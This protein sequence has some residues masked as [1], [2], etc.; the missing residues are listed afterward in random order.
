MFTKHSRS[1]SILLIQAPIQSQREN[2]QL[3][4]CGEWF[5]NN[6]KD[7]PSAVF[8]KKKALFAVDANRTVLE[9]VKV[10]GK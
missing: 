6:C 5:H 4:S 7:I 8:L 1:Q 10:V 9:G 3:F 2:D